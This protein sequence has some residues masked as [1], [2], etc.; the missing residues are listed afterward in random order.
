MRNYD[1]W[2]KSIIRSAA[3]LRGNK[4]MTIRDEGDFIRKVKNRYHKKVNNEKATMI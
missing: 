2:D 1:K 4:N 3:K